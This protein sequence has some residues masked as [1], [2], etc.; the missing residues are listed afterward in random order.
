MTT[1]RTITDE[2]RAWAEQWI[3]GL[4]DGT[5]QSLGGMPGK[6]QTAGI[7]SSEEAS[8]LRELDAASGVQPSAKAD[9]VNDALF[10]GV[11]VM[12]ARIARGL[13]VLE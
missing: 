3:S 1:T 6:L 4:R 13:G 7:I 9:I 11:T 8:A 2:Q 12:E 10:N 5:T